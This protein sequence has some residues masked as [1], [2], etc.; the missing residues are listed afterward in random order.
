MCP[1]VVESLLHASYVLAHPHD[2]TPLSPAPP[3]PPRTHQK[4]RDVISFNPSEGMI[5]A[6]T[7][8]RTFVLFVPP[9]AGRYVVRAFY[10]V[11]SSEDPVRLQWLKELKDGTLATGAVCALACCVGGIRVCGGGCCCGCCC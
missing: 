9:T 1:R 2:P 5:P 8:M 3:P 11:H 10:E 6:K 4:K 7:K